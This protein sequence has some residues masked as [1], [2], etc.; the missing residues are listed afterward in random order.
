M[1]IEPP[2]GLV[3]SGE[4]LEQAALRE[5]AEE[6]GCQADIKVSKIAGMIYDIRGRIDLLFIPTDGR[7]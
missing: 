6:T 7:S 1:S 5:L 4:S 3:E 2:S